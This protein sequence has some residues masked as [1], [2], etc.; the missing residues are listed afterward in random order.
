[1]YEWMVSLLGKWF[2]VDLLHFGAILAIVNG[3]LMLFHEFLMK[4]D[5]YLKEKMDSTPSNV[6]NKIDYYLL[7]VMG[8]LSKAINILAKLVDLLAGNKKH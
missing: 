8:I 3:G 7:K 2:N 1:M 5:S 6:D 4:L